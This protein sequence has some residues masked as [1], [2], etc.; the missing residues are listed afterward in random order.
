[1]LCRSLHA[2]ARESRLWPE[3]G[4]VVEIIYNK[5]NYSFIVVR[6]RMV[7]GGTRIVVDTERDLLINE[8]EG[9]YLHYVPE[10]YGKGDRRGNK[11]GI[12]YRVVRHALG[13]AAIPM[14]YH[15]YWIALRS[16]L[17]GKAKIGE[18]EWEAFVWKVEGRIPFRARKYLSSKRRKG[19]DRGKV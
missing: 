8:K 2:Q 17:S 10:R 3:E 9:I 4:R 12:K 15:D 18:E 16:F 13:V 11:S 14:G 19:T 1:M 5:Q 6:R 7:M